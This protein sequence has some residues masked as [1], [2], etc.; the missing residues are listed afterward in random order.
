MRVITASI[1]EKITK[2]SFTTA[3]HAMQFAS[4]KETNENAVEIDQPRQ[5]KKCTAITE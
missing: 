1:T 4:S 3:K 5:K 2:K